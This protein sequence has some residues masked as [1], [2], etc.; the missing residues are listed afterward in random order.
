MT[1][2]GFVPY[3]LTFFNEKQKNN[4][5]QNINNKKITMTK[6]QKSKQKMH[7]QES[8]ESI[9]YWNLE[10]GI[11]NLRFICNLVLEVWNFKIA[12]WVAGI[13]L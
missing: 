3:F 6:I 4:K 7:T 8:L 5:K 13:P 9:G 2:I 12:Y 10:F 1:G 11:W